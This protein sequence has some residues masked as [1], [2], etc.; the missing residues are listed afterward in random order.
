MHEDLQI[1]RFGQYRLLSLPGEQWSPL[2]QPIDLLYVARGTSSHV[3][4]ECC[5]VHLR[6]NLSIELP[7]FQKDA[8]V[9]IC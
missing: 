4:V 6:L 9:L 2:F 7:G 5:F 8:V 1:G 3:S